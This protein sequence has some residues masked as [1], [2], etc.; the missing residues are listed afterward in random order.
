MQ[1]DQFQPQVSDAV[2]DAVHRCLVDDRT[3]NYGFA[4]CLH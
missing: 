1:I 3:A 4:S 2:K